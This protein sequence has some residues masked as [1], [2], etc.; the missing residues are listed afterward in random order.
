MRVS[1]HALMD[2]PSPLILSLPH[3]LPAEARVNTLLELLSAPL[4]AAMGESSAVIAASAREREAE[5]ST[6]LGRGLAVPHARVAG[7]RQAGFCL[8][9]TEP[10]TLWQGEP[11]EMVVL[12]AVPEAF[13]ELYLQMVSSLLRQY[14]PLHKSGMLTPAALEQALRSTFSPQK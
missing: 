4:A 2:H 3:V 14:T 11:A 10:G 6:Y 12:I 7:L 5:G 13:P 9:A 8:A 1:L